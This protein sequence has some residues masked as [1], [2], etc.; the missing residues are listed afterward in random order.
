MNQFHRIIYIYIYRDESTSQNDLREKGCWC[1]LFHRTTTI[2]IN[3]RLIRFHIPELCTPTGGHTQIINNINLPTTSLYAFNAAT[4]TILYERE[5]YVIYMLI[6][7]AS[8][9]FNT[10][11]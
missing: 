2:N 6:D 1:L 9:A 3:T 4:S 11:G 7:R 8:S 10:L 5:R